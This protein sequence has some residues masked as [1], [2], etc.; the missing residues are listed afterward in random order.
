MTHLFGKIANPRHYLQF[1]LSFLL[2][3]LVITTSDPKDICMYCPDVTLRCII[4]HL[5]HVVSLSTCYVLSISYVCLYHCIAY[6]VYFHRL[7]VRLLRMSLNINQL[8]MTLTFKLELDKCQGEMV[9]MFIS[10][11]PHTDTVRLLYLSH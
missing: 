5:Y 2:L 4:S 9:K 1:T 3:N 6:T 8:I 11:C 10:H 7:H